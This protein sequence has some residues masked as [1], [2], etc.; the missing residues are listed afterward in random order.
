M[1]V[2]EEIGM[3]SFETIVLIIFENR[4]L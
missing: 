2:V 3:L 4:I 1:Q